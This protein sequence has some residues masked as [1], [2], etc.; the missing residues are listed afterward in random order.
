MRELPPA[1]KMEYVLQRLTEQ[2]ELYAVALL[3]CTAGYI[4]PMAKAGMF[5]LTDV[6]AAVSIKGGTHVLNVGQEGLWAPWKKKA[7]SKLQ[8][9]AAVL[10]GRI[11]PMGCKLSIPFTWC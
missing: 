7:G 5:C 3:C 9:R 4:A 8:T 10:A 6:P 1:F 11:Q 2:L